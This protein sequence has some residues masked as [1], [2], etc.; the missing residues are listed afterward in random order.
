LK[1]GLRAGGFTTLVDALL[2]GFEGFGC[3]DASGDDQ[4]RGHVWVDTTE[5]VVGGMVQGDAVAI[6]ALPSITTHR[7]EAFGGL[8]QGLE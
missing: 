8:L 2:N 7:V 4:L 6:M 1:I 5:A 3:L